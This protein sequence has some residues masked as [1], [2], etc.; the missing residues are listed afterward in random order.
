MQDAHQIRLEIPSAAEYVSVVRRAVEGIATRM[1]FAPSD[2]ED[3]KL[4]VGEACNNAVKHGCP[5]HNRP[6]IT[7]ICKVTPGC[8]E[9]EIK[10][11]LAGEEPC[12]AVVEPP[13]GSKEGGMGLHIMRQLMDEVDII[14]KNRTASIRMV[15]RLREG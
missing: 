7:V 3:L 4:A 13:D 6:F 14:W 9:I 10:N 2:V 8:L 15:K 5:S 1:H 11:G 12:P